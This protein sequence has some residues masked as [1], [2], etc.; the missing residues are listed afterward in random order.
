MSP[1][2]ARSGIFQLPFKGAFAA[3]GISCQAV[4]GI[5]PHMVPV[6]RRSVP[7]FSPGSQL[8]RAAAFLQGPSLTEAASIPHAYGRR[9]IPLRG[10]LDRQPPISGQKGQNE[11]GSGADQRAGGDVG[12][13]LRPVGGVEPH[14]G[15]ALVVLHVGHGF[16]PIHMGNADGA[17][18]FDAPN[19]Y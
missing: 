8:W 3:S 14:L 18:S 11:R 12:R 7:G 19:C 9:D 1:P 13:K 4:L 16:H 2:V 5:R 6:I 10:R 15:P 17:I